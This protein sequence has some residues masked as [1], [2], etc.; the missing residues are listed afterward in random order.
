MTSMMP[1]ASLTERVNGRPAAFASSAAFERIAPP[2]KRCC[3]DRRRNVPRSDCCYPGLSRRAMHGRPLR[4]PP[5]FVTSA[6][7]VAARLAVLAHGARALTSPPQGLAVAAARRLRSL[8]LCRRSRRRR[9]RCLDSH[10]HRRRARR[11]RPL[12]LLVSATLEGRARDSCTS[13]AMKGVWSFPESPC[14]AT[15]PRPLLSPLPVARLPSPRRACCP[16]EA[17]IATADVADPAATSCTIAQSCES[18]VH[19]GSNQSLFA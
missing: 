18:V 15:P 2:R 11:R 6:A 1:G 17:A 9:S 12:A 14:A 8:R 5:S 3:G 19:G 10:R 16:A 7:T 13:Q 4:S